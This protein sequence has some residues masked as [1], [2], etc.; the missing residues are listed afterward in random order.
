MTSHHHHKDRAIHKRKASQAIDKTRHLNLRKAVKTEA[1]SLVFQF[2]EFNNSTVSSNDDDMDMDGGDEMKDLAK[3][4]GPEACNPNRPQWLKVLVGTAKLEGVSVAHV[5]AH[6]VERAE[7]PAGWSS[8]FISGRESKSREDHELD[9]L[10]WSVFNQ[11]GGLR[12]QHYTH[13]VKRGSGVWA[14]EVGKGFLVLITYVAVCKEWRRE[15]VGRRL[16][17]GIDEMVASMV[18]DIPSTGLSRR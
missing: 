14:E 13:E 10:A 2:F 3:L 9:Q 15:G 7:E 16:V 8:R 4:I 17:L 1:D 5:V 12:K 6:I 18:S 11:R